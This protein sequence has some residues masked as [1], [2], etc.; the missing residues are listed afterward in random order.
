MEMARDDRELV[1][2]VQDDAHEVPETVRKQSE[3]TEF[4]LVNSL[5]AQLGGT[6]VMAATD[7]GVSATVRFPL[8][9]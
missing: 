5:V 6:I 8:E 2:T 1:I 9:T 4:L 3:T 7:G